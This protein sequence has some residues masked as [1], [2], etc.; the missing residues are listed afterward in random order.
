MPALQ[1]EQWI[2]DSITRGYTVEQVRED[3][4]KN[5]YSTQSIAALTSK[6]DEPRFKPH[7][8]IRN[9]IIVAL[10]AVF[11]IIA[12]YW[13]LSESNEITI[14]AAQMEKY[15]AENLENGIS[16][17]DDGYLRFKINLPENMQNVPI[18]GTIYAYGQAVNT[19]SLIAVKDVYYTFS[20]DVDEI[21]ALPDVDEQIISY[22]TEV[23]NR[24]NFELEPEKDI[25]VLEAKKFIMDLRN[26]FYELELQSVEVSS[27]RRFIE[28]LF[29]ESLATSS[30]KTQVKANYDIVEISTAEN[31]L[32]VRYE[33]RFADQVV[34]PGLQVYSR[35]E[36]LENFLI[37]GNNNYETYEFI[38]TPIGS[39]LIMK[40]A[41]NNGNAIT[42]FA[43]P[44]S[45]VP[46]VE[47]F[48]Q[49]LVLEPI[50]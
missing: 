47:L 19:E 49:K 18:K 3:L 22:T 35:D 37:K 24:G 48:I 12:I 20:L 29:A 25:T 14:N 34:Y 6:L 16:L 33:L 5:G 1:V 50:N 7:L 23:N 31:I 8:T 43:G 38:F 44:N 10:I 32:I 17:S 4:R 39:E 28:D 2:K 9:S 42:Q 13:L 27:K 46:D 40:L 36:Q 41:L 11:T 21:I 45:D 30:Q 15:Q 26:D